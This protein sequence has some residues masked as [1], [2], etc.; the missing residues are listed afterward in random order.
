MS[1]DSF[2]C[3]QGMVLA[4]AFVRFNVDVLLFDDFVRSG[5]Y[6][7]NSSPVLATRKFNADRSR[8]VR[9]SVQM[10]QIVTTSFV[11]L[12]LS[13][14][15]RTIVFDVLC[16]SGTWTFPLSSAVAL[17]QFPLAVWKQISERGF[18]DILTLPS[19]F[20]AVTLSRYDR[21]DP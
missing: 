16:G 8:K 6:D 17:L 13:S 1:N 4:V 9:W 18:A 19:V 11:Q 12:F 20:A 14:S 10:T 15:K 21:S 2:V 3:L 5:L 7:G